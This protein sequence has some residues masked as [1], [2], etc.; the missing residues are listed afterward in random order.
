MKVAQL[1]CCEGHASRTAVPPGWQV[2]LTERERACAWKGS[3]HLHTMYWI[4]FFLC[5]SFIP[6][7]ELST[8]LENAPS[9]VLV[10]SSRIVSWLTLIPLQNL[11]LPTTTVG[12]HT[13]NSSPTQ[14]T[15]WKKIDRNHNHLVRTERTDHRSN[16]RCPLLSRAAVPPENCSIS[17]STIRGNTSPT[18]SPH[19]HKHL[20]HN[21]RCGH[22]SSCSRHPPSIHLLL[23][24]C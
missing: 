12:G 4:N 2:V 7:T 8:K 20:P 13:Q 23:L 1:S 14:K 16:P 19:G 22:I 18:R 3:T 15:H 10:D 9:V 6:S 11:E 21:T 24:V 17:G 5:A